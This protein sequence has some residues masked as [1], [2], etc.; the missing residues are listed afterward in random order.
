M[1]EQL[2]V[3]K[4]VAT[5][6]QAAGIAYMV[7]GSTAMNYYAQPRMTRDIDFIVDLLPDEG[8][9]FARVFSDDFYCDV[10]AVREAVFGR[11]PPIGAKSSH[12][13]AV[14]SSTV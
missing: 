5:R 1:S 10:A 13:V 12:V 4:I 6:L 11:R 14:W 7:S 8:E 9:R 2:V 3:L